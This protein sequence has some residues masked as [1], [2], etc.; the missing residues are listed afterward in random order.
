MFAL[1]INV[2]KAFSKAKY[3]L[4]MLKSSVND[5]VT[6]LNANQRDH[7]ARITEL[8]QSIHIL[9]NRITELENIKSPSSAD[10]DV[11]ELR[12]L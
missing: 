7:A 10:R 12:M 2:K 1:E 9:H 3:D 5:W 6:F 11:F 8:E 4:L